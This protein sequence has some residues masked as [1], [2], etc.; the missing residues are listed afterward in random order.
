M[1][2]TQNER[3]TFKVCYNKCLCSSHPKATAL[4]L[5]QNNLRALPYYL[6]SVWIKCET[7]STHY[8]KTSILWARRNY[9]DYNSEA[10]LDS[11][12][13]EVKTH[14]SVDSVN[15]KNENRSMSQWRFNSYLI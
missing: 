11:F 1:N 10:V 3:L 4:K 2:T 13:E 14:V 5:F 7:D 12:H 8:I 9:I 15:C 6:G